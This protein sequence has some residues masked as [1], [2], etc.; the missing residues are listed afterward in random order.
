MA[1]S[2]AVGLGLAVLSAATFGTAGPFG[3]SLLAAGWSPA[4]AATV[5]IG[6]AALVLAVPAVR[7]L[8]GRWALLRRGWAAAVGYGIGAVAVPQLF[9]FNAVEHLSV[10]VALLL[11]YCGTLLVV[12]W[13]WLVHGQRPTR[14]TTVGGVL[15]IG[16]LVLVLDLTGSQRVDLVGVLW[17]LG[18][19]AGLA[20]YFVLSS[21]TTAAAEDSLP[22]IAMAGVGMVVAALGLLVV[23]LVG[24]LPFRTATA[25]VRLA[26]TL[27]PWLVP[28][29][30]VAL[31]A[32]VTAY[33]TG[34]AAARRL[35]A[36]VAS[37]VGLA[38][39]LFAIVF[40]W[41][42]L[43]QRPSAWQGVGAIVVLAGIA[44]VRLGDNPRSAPAVVTESAQIATTAGVRRR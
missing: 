37:F 40:A 17:A 3:D 2:G 16:G 38:E 30:G 41:V 6:L 23:D 42:L 18:A 39:V 35:G 13:M 33:V 25:D 27:L 32:T 24:V 14:L 34:I 21:S 31:V 44:L 4:G 28:V 15:A 9:F 12:L 20:S 29:V 8:R 7:A 10:G 19:A 43:D 5:R 11:E 36:R 26:G 1:R 22:P